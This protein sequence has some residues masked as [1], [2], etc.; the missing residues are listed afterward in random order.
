MERVSK[1]VLP[2]GAMSPDSL[3]KGASQKLTG[4]FLP[5]QM[6]PLPVYPGLHVQL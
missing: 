3:I 6:L 1:G 2:K 4:K 5:L